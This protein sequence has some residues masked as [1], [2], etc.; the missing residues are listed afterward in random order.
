V[1]ALTISRQLPPLSR[2]GPEPAQDAN[3]FG[4]NSCGSE[5]PAMGRHGSVLQ[6]VAENIGGAEESHGRN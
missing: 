6:W 5:T 3:W 1:D 4:R 2:Q